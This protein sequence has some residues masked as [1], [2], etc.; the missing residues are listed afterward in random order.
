MKSCTFFG[1][2]DCPD[3]IEK[4][5]WDTIEWLIKHEGVTWFYVGDSGNFDRLVLKVL[6]GLENYLYDIDICVMLAYFPT[7]QSV[8]ED[9]YTLL[10][11]G[12]EEVPK[13]FAIDY[14]NKYML[15]RSEYVITYVVADFGG[16]AKYAKRAKR[17]KKTVINIA[18]I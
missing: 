14:R 6:K 8:I 15:D 16:A 2:R 17:Q 11:E 4:K 10:P 3:N 13:R 1:H 5:L 7:E 18:E 12:I 9:N